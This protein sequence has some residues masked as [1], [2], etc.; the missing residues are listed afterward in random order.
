MIRVTKQDPIRTG[1]GTAT[2]T[3][4][5]IAW[6]SEEEFNTFQ[7]SSGNDDDTTSTQAP[8][9]SPPDDTPPT[10]QPPTAVPTEAP[11]LS[12]PLEEELDSRTMVLASLGSTHIWQKL[13]QV[14][15]MI[16]NT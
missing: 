4:H 13:V 7:H 16:P 1:S 14:L 10:T 2:Y 12:P 15:I 3:F 5:A 9:P 11:V 6:P 8:V